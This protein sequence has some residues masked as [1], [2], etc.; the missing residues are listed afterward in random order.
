[1]KIGAIK[2]DHIPE[3]WI[4]L[5]ET[6]SWKKGRGMGCITVYLYNAGKGHFNV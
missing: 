5:K 1:M 6:K 3:K 4:F 2:K